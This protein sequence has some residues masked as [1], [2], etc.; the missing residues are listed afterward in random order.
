MVFPLILRKITGES[1]VPALKSGQ[2]VLGLRIIRNLKEG[3]VVI[4]SHSG[5]EKVKR[6]HS[7]H[8]NGQ[9]EL[10]GDNVALST[11]SRQF[12]LVHKGQIVARVIG[13]R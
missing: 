5:T 13:V 2:L 12:G 1:M 6:I 4:V 9:I 3:M 8:R 7:I 10:R 11:D